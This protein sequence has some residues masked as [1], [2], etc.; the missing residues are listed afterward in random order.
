MRAVGVHQGLAPVLDVTRDP[1]G[2]AP[3]RRSARTRTW[4]A[5]SAPPTCAGWSGAASSP[6]SSTSS[7]TPPRAAGRN[8]APGRRSGRASSPTCSCRRSRWRSATAAPARSCTPTPRSTACPSAADRGAAHRRCCATR[9]ASTARSSPTTSASRSCSACTAS[10]ATRG[11]GGR[12]GAAPP[13]STSSCPASRC[14]GAPLR[15]RVRRAAP[16]TRRW[17]TGRCGGCCA[18]KA[19]LGLLDADWTPTR[20][21]PTDARS[22]STDAGRAGTLARRLAE[23]SVVLLANDGALPLRPD[24]RVAVVGPHADDPMAMLGCYPSPR[25]VGVHHPDVPTRRRDPD[26]ARRAARALDRAQVDATRRGC[27]GRRRRHARGSPP[28]SPRRRRRRRVR[29]RARRP[30][31]AVRPRHVGEGCDADDLR[32]PGVQAR[33]ARGGAGHGHAGRRWC[34]WPGGRTRSARYA[35]GAAAVVQAFFPGEEGGP[36]RRRRC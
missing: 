24:A 25:H 31:R 16:S 28:P 26:R 33:A 36:A 7:A 8:L 15:G 10:R 3:R 23:E 20:R 17:S 18:Q 27:D 21:G 30:G 19:E 14:Y 22:T 12:A 13:A 32:L 35:D 9:G 4:S 1:A 5:P 6:R 34:C 29:R 11:R 2:A